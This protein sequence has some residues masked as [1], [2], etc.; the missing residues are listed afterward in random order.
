M[1]ATSLV[2]AIVV[3]AAA[4]PAFALPGFDGDNNPIPGTS[5]VQKQAISPDT[6]AEA[7]RGARI[8]VPRRVPKAGGR[9]ERRLF[10]KAQGL[11]E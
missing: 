3:L 8:F 6:R 1:T 9:I 7:G 5:R 10:D 11:P 4:S 2:V